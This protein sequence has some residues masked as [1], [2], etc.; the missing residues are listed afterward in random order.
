MKKGLF[1]LGN[2]FL[3]FLLMFLCSSCTSTKNVTYFNNISDTTLQSMRA[4]IEPVIQKGDLLSI[5]VSSLSPEAATMFNASNAPASSGGMYSNA[6]SEA[7]GYLVSQKGNID[8]PI[9]GTIQVAG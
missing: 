2:V 7:V 1:F 8:F 5:S 9:L 3:F 6:L 4:G